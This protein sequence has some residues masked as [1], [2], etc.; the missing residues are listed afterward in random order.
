MNEGE[1]KSEIFG[2][3]AKSK[4]KTKLEE[5][6][7]AVVEK[8]ND[9]ICIIQDGMIVYANPKVLE[10]GGYKKNEIVGK[11]FADFIF[12]EE[13]EE[14]LKKYKRRMRGGKVEEI[15]EMIF[16][17][18]DGSKVCAQITVTLIDYRGKPAELV[19]IRDITEKKEIKEKYG[20]MIDALE[21]YAI[22]MLD[23]KGNVISWNKG[24][25]RI[26]GYKAHEVLGK[27][28]S[29]FYTE[30]DRKEGK[31]EKEL[32]MAVKK[33]KIEVEGWRV[34][35]DGSR[36]WAD[37]VITTLKD[38]KL[39]GFV[40]VTQDLTERKKMEEA[41]REERN[42]FI[43]GPVVVFKWKAGEKK[44]PVEY[45]SPNIKNVFGYKPQEFTKG[46]IRYEDIVHP[47]DLERIV[48][49]I[50]YYRKK[51][52]PYFEQEYRIIDAK[53]NERWVHDF[54][55]VRKN[56]EGKITHYHGYIVDITEKKMAE[57]KLRK[58][59]RMFKVLYKCNE[60]LVFAKSKKGLMDK[61]CRVIAEEGG[62]P[63][64]WIG[65]VEKN[66]EVHPAAVVGKAKEYVKKLKITLDNGKYGNCPTWTAIETGNPSVVRD[67]EE[68]AERTPWKK[69]ATK[70]GLKS[71][72][73][74][75]LIANG[76]VVGALNIYSEERDAFQREEITFL[77]QLAH[78]LAY[79]IVF[80]ETREREKKMERKLEKERAQILSIF[81]GIDEPIYVADPETYK[82]LYVNNALKKFFGKNITGKKC[83][84]VFQGLDKP[85]DF[86]T[87]DKIF[88]ENFEKTYVWE[89]E[90]KKV[91]RWYRCFDRGITW[92]D[93]RKVRLEIAMDITDRVHAEQKWREALEQERQFKLDTAHYF[94]NPIAIAKGYL[95]LALEEKG[96]EEDKIRKAI[97]AIER[98]ENVV[99]NVTQKGEIRE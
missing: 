67:M 82:I 11:P 65:V 83:Y 51:Q 45:V 54:T 53:G 18:K 26:K 96:E 89:F 40:K 46:K 21:D 24:A 66:K 76:K 34:R 73:A 10:M 39:R 80:L 2:R 3:D 47:E 20:A 77:S 23:E 29:I 81:E 95:Q 4:E 99:K 5:M 86:C 84:E 1:I 9:G 49:E 33:G 75:P 68:N 14:I 15:Y 74:I 87:N 35:K 16:V 78:D 30:E 7:K 32:R 98:V 25:E 17:R 62:Y 8:A 48:K 37:V 43:S 28:F 97:K 31:P 6:Y 22:F 64:V 59:N 88:G 12:S 57:E 41:L 27:H 50:Q 79:G 55:I 44:I 92:P 93:G 60:V 19:I 52:I 85:C 42:L 94:F 36:F 90:N 58:S 56:G 61:V 70:Y 69:K 13:K 71:S 72:I 91:G 63:L 38:R